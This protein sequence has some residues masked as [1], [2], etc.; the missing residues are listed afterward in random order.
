MGF[1]SRRAALHA[2]TIDKRMQPR[3]D[4]WNQELQRNLKQNKNLKATRMHALWA[5]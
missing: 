1:L 4:R 2:T 3:G 5:K